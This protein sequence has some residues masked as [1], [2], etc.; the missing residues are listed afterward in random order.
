MFSISGIVH[1]RSNA[2]A[3]TILNIY[4]NV[5][6]AAKLNTHQLD[7]ISYLL[8]IDAVTSTAE[9]QTGFHSFRKA[10]GLGRL[11]WVE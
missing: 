9:D 10:F 4:N 11:E 1:F 6:T 8:H 5:S 2:L 7:R 3:R